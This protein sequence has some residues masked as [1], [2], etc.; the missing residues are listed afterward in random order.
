MEVAVVCRKASRAAISRSGGGLDAITP[1]D[2]N[3][4]LA[5]YRFGPVNPWSSAIPPT[6]SSRARH[7]AAAGA[8]RQRRSPLMGR[9]PAEVRNYIYVLVFGGGGGL[10]SLEAGCDREKGE[11]EEAERETETEMETKKLPARAQNT[12]NLLT[13]SPPSNAL[14][15]C[16]RKSYREAGELYREAYRRY[17]RTTT[18]VLEERSSLAYDFLPPFTDRDLAE[19]RH[20]YFFTSG[21]LLCD[22]R[23]G[24]GGGSRGVMEMLR[25]SFVGCGGELELELMRCRD[26]SWACLNFGFVHAAPHGHGNGHGHRFMLVPERRQGDRWGFVGVLDGG[27]DEGLEGIGGR[28]YE[29]VRKGELSALL[30]IEIA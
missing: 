4:S 23:V 15:L 24:D 8:N 28:E 25:S 2:Q 11:K 26:G 9:V 19:I 5:K 20:L 21:K 13:A 3:T 29:V 16:C 12:Q 1:I 18:F 7:T 30:D 6:P 22:G 10:R 17:W 14:L 27:F